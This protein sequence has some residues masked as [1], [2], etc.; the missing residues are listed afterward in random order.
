MQID[1]GTAAPKIADLNQA[2]ALWAGH[3]V[4]DIIE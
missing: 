1:R 4:N 2:D 3:Q